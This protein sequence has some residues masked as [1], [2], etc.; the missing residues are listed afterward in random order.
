MSME[1]I[2]EETRKEQL[3]D[4]IEKNFRSR[5]RCFMDWASLGVVMSGIFFAGGIVVRNGCRDLNYQTECLY[6]LSEED[7][8]RREKYEGQIFR[9]FG[10]STIE[11]IITVDRRLYSSRHRENKKPDMVGFSDCPAENCSYIVKYVLTEDYGM[12][13]KGWINGNIGRIEYVDKNIT[14]KIF[15]SVI[16]EKGGD[17]GN[18][19][20]LS[21]GPT[22]CLYK[23]FRQE[24]TEEEK[25]SKISEPVVLHEIGHANSWETDLKLSLLEREEMILLVYDRMTSPDAW[26]DDHGQKYYELFL[27]GNM[28]YAYEGTEEYW[29]SICCE[30]FNDPKKFQEKFPAD[31]NLVDKYV[32]KHD[33]KFNV[34]DPNRGALD[35]KT[36][37]LKD[38]WQKKEMTP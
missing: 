13:P 7:M 23:T 27:N 5:V 38:C 35:P 22:L 15:D 3:P 19:F 16:A 25:S 31:F 34:L 26:H 18:R 12:F 14:K 11:R 37:K 36:G 2:G 33:P 4:I 30:Y 1:Q 6:N 28:E 24:P 20:N 10:E 21:D 9:I 8:A 29:A 32:K 17:F